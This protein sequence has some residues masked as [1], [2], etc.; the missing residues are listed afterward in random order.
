[1]SVHLKKQL[2]FPWLPS[3]LHTYPIIHALLHFLTIVKKGFRKISSSCIVKSEFLSN[4]RNFYWAILCTYIRPWPDRTKLEGH[5]WV[6]ALKNLTYIWY[7]RKDICQSIIQLT[8]FNV[9][10]CSFHGR[11]KL[12]L[13]FRSYFLCSKHHFATKLGLHLLKWRFRNMHVSHHHH[14]L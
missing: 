2:H 6:E 1:M 8:F 7:L 12:R 14:F 4:I 9:L 13:R 10:W 11:T 3:I 5:Q